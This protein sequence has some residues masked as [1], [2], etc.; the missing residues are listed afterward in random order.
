[1]KHEIHSLTGLRGIAAF[2]V[3]I[4]HF[5]NGFFI[6]NYQTFPTALNLFFKNTISHGYLSVDIFF[7]LS[8]FVL[9]LR[10]QNEFKNKMEIN[11]YQNFMK[12]RF[13]RIYPVYF[14]CIIFTMLVFKN[15]SIYNF[16]FESLLL[17]AYTD[18]NLYNYNIATWSLSIEWTIYLIFPFI[19]FVLQKFSKIF[20]ITLLIVSFWI[21]YHIQFLSVSIFNFRLMAISKIEPTYNLNIHFG[22][23]ALLRALIS[24]FLGYLI[25]KYHKFFNH[26]II[27]ILSIILII[28]VVFY[29]VNDVFIIILFMF[30]FAGLLKENFISKFLQSPPLIYLGKISYSLYLFHVVIISIVRQYSLNSNFKVDTLSFFTVPVILSLLFAVLSYELFEKR[31]TKILFQ[32]K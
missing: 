25:F 15:F 16:I 2:Y 3:M 6:K 13:K 1:M 26:K 20:L 30:F 22:F 19:L 27:F 4:F 11:S 29:N 23:L 32:V 31:L 14:I 17:N 8:S 5:M 18:I 9:C 10:Y 7:M 12:R 24:Y 21:L 28:P